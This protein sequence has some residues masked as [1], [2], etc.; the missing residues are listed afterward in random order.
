[1]QAPPPRELVEVQTAVGSYIKILE[2]KFPQRSSAV[3]M[4][5]DDDYYAEA[6]WR[7]ECNGHP[8]KSY[9]VTDDEFLLE[10]KKELK[11]RFGL[12]IIDQEEWARRTDPSPFRV[13]YN[14]DIGDGNGPLN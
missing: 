8:E 11:S 2:S 9:Y 5:W 6:L 10:F 7:W 1:M 13:V 14:P 4:V 3:M 12:E